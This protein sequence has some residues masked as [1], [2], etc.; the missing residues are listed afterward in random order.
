MSG[1]RPPCG[2]EPARLS[3]RRW[4]PAE[5]AAEAEG[6]EKTGTSSGIMVE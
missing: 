5:M 1:V 4:A 2:Y 3:S 6:G